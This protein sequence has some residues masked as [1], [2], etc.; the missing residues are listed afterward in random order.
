MVD[1]QCCSLTCFDPLPLGACIVKIVMTVQMELVLKNTPVNA[2]AVRDVCSLPGSGRSPGEGNGNPL[3]Y[4]CL[5]NLIDRGAWQATVHSV[6]K[7]GH[8]WATK[9]THI[10]LK[11]WNLS[12]LGKAP[13]HPDKFPCS[14][15]SFP[16]IK[17]STHIIFWLV[18]MWH[19]FLHP[20]NYNL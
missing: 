8:D 6:T 16:E 5:E 18:L 4:S 2:E 19:L 7:S 3:L 1:L 11:N 17:I 13:F 10:F 20:F 9:H 12:L 15:S 14:E